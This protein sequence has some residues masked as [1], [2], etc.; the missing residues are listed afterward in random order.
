M[1]VTHLEAN[2]ASLL[3]DIHSSRPRKD[4][5]F[6]TKVYLLA[7]PSTEKLKVNWKSYIEL[8][9]EVDSSQLLNEE[10]EGE[11]KNLTAVA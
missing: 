4:F 11:E 5:P 10:D 1:D 8:V 9:P 6:I 2:Y 7:P 3:K